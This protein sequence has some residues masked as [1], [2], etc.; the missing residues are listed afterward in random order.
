MTLVFLL[1]IMLTSEMW[2]GSH[3]DGILHKNITCINTQKIPDYRENSS[4]HILTD[5]NITQIKFP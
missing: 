4:D 1:S 5:I 2:E 3:L